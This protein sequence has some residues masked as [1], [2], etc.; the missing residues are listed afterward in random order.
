MYI[1]T[2]AYY[3]TYLLIT[4]GL[5]MYIYI[6]IY[7]YIHIFIYI[8]ILTKVYLRYIYR[9]WC[10]CIYIYIYIYIYITIVISKP[11]VICIRALVMCIVGIIYDFSETPIMEVQHNIKWL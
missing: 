6:Y 3:T 9:Y 8:Y 11:L 4:Y 10:I 5:Y 2:D 7:I 1:A